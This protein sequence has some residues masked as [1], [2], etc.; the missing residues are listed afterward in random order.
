MLCWVQTNRRKLKI[1]RKNI[2]APVTAEVGLGRTEKAVRNPDRCIG[3][4]LCVSA[5]P[6]AAIAFGRLDEGHVAIPQENYINLLLT[7][8]QEKGKPLLW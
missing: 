2:S 8:A 5:C 1:R 3:C 7:I 4:G 6:T